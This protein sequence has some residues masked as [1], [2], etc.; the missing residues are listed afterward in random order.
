MW[1]SEISMNTILTSIFVFV[2]LAASDSAFSQTAQCDAGAFRQVVASASGSITELH[3]KNNK[4]FQEKLQKLRVSNNW[5]EAEYVAKATPFVKDDVTLSIDAANQALLAK[6]QSLEA[7]TASSEAGRCAMLSELKLSMDKVVENT[8][9]RWQHML[10]K[11]TQAT[12]VPMQ[13]GV[14]Q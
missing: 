2:L 3:D 9:A 5:S 6:V 4:L 1:G 14:T 8:A 12:D 11:L 7:A 10:T 13:A